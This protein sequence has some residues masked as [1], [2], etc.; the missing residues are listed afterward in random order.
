MNQNPR[1]ILKASSVE[2]NRSSMLKEVSFSIRTPSLISK[3]LRLEG[4]RNH[5][6]VK[7]VRANKRAVTKL[8][9]SEISRSLSIRSQA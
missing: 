8:Q 2:E 7:L 4:A 6:G 1:A 5:G 3:W 9:E